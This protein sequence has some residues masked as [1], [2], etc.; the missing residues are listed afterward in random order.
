MNALPAA[1][2]SGTT[3]VCQNAAAPTIAFTGTNG[4]APY[5][6]TYTINGG[7]QQTVASSGNTA[8]VTVPTGTAGTFT[9][10]LVSVKDASST[11]CTATVSGS[12]TVT[13]NALP[14][15]TISGTTSVCLNATAP[16]ITFT[17]ANA[18]APYTF[19]Y[20]INGGSQQTVTSSGNT[21]T[22][23]V[24]TG[25]AG[26]FTYALVS[27]KD[28]SATLCSNGVSGS[29]VVTINA[30]PAPVISASG[31]TTICANGSSV[32]LSVQ[33]GGAGNALTFSS[34]KY[35]DVPTNASLNMGTTTDFTYEAWV[36]LN[37]SQANYAGIVIKELSRHL[38]NW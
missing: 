7:A 6:F 2:I 11:L 8:T 9:Y 25:T 19:T 31:P 23:T 29:A 21:A 4:T 15:A 28:A 1:T 12:A 34:G 27:V 35:V 30:L 17:G 18:T 5:T 3:S 33:G 13:V 20:T 36:K 24:P 38:P 26:V 32:T 16:T 37:G 22:V 10:A 14:A